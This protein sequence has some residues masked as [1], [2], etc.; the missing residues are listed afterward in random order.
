MIYPW[1]Y[2]LAQQL[3]MVYS[4]HELKKTGAWTTFQ[5]VIIMD[6]MDLHERGI[7]QLGVIADKLGCDI[8]GSTDDVDLASIPSVMQFSVA[9]SGAGFLNRN[10]TSSASPA[11]T[12][13]SSPSMFRLTPTRRGCRVTGTQAARMR[14]RRC[15]S[16]R[17]C[18]RRTPRC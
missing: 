6:I 12:Y 5:E 11:S 16:C 13:T 17:S 7:V 3:Q 14:S 10:S 1:F 9:I 4:I 18:A 2:R 15:S 8:S